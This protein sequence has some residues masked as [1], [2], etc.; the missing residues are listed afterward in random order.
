M[1][2]QTAMIALSQ[3]HSISKVIK[4]ILAMNTPLAK[5]IKE[6]LKQGYNEDQI[7]EYLTKGKSQS[8]SQRNKMLKDMTEEEKGRGIL[9]HQSKSEK[10]I[11]NII[12]GAAMTA[13]GLAAG[14]AAA[15]IAGAALRRA[16][17]Q[18]FGQGAIPGAAGMAANA[19]MPP[20][21]TSLG[22]QV[23]NP[24]APTGNQTQTPGQQTPVTNLQSPQQPPVNESRVTQPTVSPQPEVIS[25]P[26]E[27]LEKL[28][29]LDRVKSLLKAG[30]T[31][32]GVAAA[33]GMKRSGETKIDPELLKNI[34]EYA[35][36]KP[37]EAVEPPE[38]SKENKIE[39]SSIVASPHGVGEVKAIRNGKAIVEIDG[40]K[41]QVNENELENEPEE[42]KKS[43]IS[44]DIN[45]VSEDLRSAP[46]NEVYI[47]SHKKH[48]TVKFN[49][50][51]GVEKDKR[52]LYY[53]KDGQP[54]DPTIIE[55]LRVGTKLPVTS[56]DSF[57]GAWDADEQDSRGTVAFHELTRQAQRE[58]EEN[59]PSKPYWFVEEEEVFTHG[60]R[61][62]YEK[63]LK[64]K[65]KAFNEERKKR[66]KKPT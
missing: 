3:G 16:A 7:G 36:Q 31:P 18:I 8:Y 32:E 63:H 33:I 27:Y 9:Y 59:D 62:E 15:P 4:S 60:Y 56:G 48:I 11:G 12:K 38:E 37:A 34:E 58:G 29:I 66:K 13:P 42:V 55:N 35:K 17:P 40:K 26:K 44:F 2:L 50:N 39:P 53:R 20:G 21:P 47:P 6:A 49:A 45:K 61:K 25:N 64:Q 28:G 54:V 52:Y 43:V 19:P 1:T 30:N 23:L 46:L 14:Y 51:A 57:W 41:H 5:S 65:E 22:V 24:N 10:N